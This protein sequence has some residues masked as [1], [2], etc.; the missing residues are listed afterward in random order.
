MKIYTKVG[1]KGT[2]SLFGGA[3]VNKD[4]IRLEAY[5][6]VDE[7][8]AHIGLLRDISN[9]KHQEDFLMKIQ[10]ELFVM[11]SILASESREILSKVPQL[12]EQSITDL[13]EEIDELEK[14][15]RPL[16]KFILPG[17]HQHVSFCHIART[18]CR[19]CERKVVTMS[20]NIEVNNIIVKYLNRLSD[21]LFVLAR[22]MAKDL[23]VSEVYWKGKET[24]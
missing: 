9:D 4:D 8:N 7:L 16:T 11:A 22:K 17:G 12:K 15:L 21:Y 1:D 14:E 10:N 18:V 13:E 24:L 2:T 3:I 23:N 19:R 6:T 5:G 20:Q